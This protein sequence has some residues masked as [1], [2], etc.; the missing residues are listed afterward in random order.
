GGGLHLTDRE[1][2]FTGKTMGGSLTLENVSGEARL[3]TMGGEIRL[4][5]S[6][7][8]GFLKTMGGKVTFRD[9]V[10][11]VEGS[12][13][14][15]NVRYQNVRRR[16]G[17]FASPRGEAV[18]GTG[19]DTVQISTMGGSIEVDEAPQGANLHTMG[20]SIHIANASRFVKAKTMGGDIEIED[21]EGW[22]QATT[23][24]GD[25]VV[26]VMPGSRGD[27]ELVSMSG[28]IELR[29]PADFSM[30]LDLQ[31]AYTRNSSK[32]YRI[33]SDF[34]FRQEQSSSWDYGKGTPRKYIYGTGSLGGGQN[35]IR[36]ET[37]N[38][39]IYLRKK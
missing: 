6:D 30:D 31:I 2:T 37:I 19:A 4:T 16:S 9:V 14:G 5:D 10:G 8:D 7:L 3:T 27:I 33:V 23:M 1:G 18:E 21:S 26:S 38:G 20:G 35:R 11:D 36:I 12:S 34:N 15:G 39:N 28:D 32:S 22:I 29:V 13:M 24:G 25:I 17:E